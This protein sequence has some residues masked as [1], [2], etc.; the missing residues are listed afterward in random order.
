M[1]TLPDWLV[2]RAA[3]D[4]VPS[5]SRA[6]LQQAPP[7][8]LTARVAAL[9]EAN[10]REL[11][12]YPP[13]PAVAQ[14]EARLRRRPKRRRTWVAPLVAAAGLAAVLL[15]VTRHAPRG[16]EPETT[17]VKGAARLLV[18]K[19]VGEQAEKLDADA[20]VRAGDVI[21][22]RYNAGGAR[23]G[24]IASI[25]GSGGVTLHFPASEDAPNDVAGGTRTL[26]EAF[27]LDDAP[28]FERFF[29]VTANEPIDTAATLDALRA[30]A[31]RGDAADA[32]L[33]LRPGLH[34]ASL[35]LRKP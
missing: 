5:A 24:V 21:Q 29:F 1:T 27:A 34:Q 32:V 19:Q 23:Y 6:R 20:V 8:E 11:A 4:E 18:F 35:R 3:L 15:V 28:R 22:L 14:I 26:P 10:A 16:A 2:E 9:R 12:A 30:L 25:D 31:R 33:D 13:G 17:R 7:G